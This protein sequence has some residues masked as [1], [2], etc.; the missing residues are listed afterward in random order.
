MK[1]II[2]Y[3]SPKRGEEFILS[4]VKPV[5]LDVDAACGCLK[6]PSSVS[7]YDPVVCLQFFRPFFI[8]TE[9]MR[10]IT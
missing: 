5:A 3:K 9:Y 10:N 1:V 7:F 2:F 4:S 6:T 8:F